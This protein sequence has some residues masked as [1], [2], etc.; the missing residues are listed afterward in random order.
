MLLTRI[1]YFR[2]VILMSFECPHCHFKNSEIQSAGQIQERGCKYTFTITSLADIQRQVIKSD[3]CVCSFPLLDLEIPAQR[4][5]L[6]TIEG[7]LSTVLEDLTGD[8][9]KRKD[10]DPETWQKIDEFINKGKDMLEGKSFP[11]DVVIDDISGNSWV[12]PSPSDP[13]GKWVRRD[14]LRTREQNEELSLEH[15]PEK[16]MGTVGGADGP[17]DEITK[18]EVYCFPASCPNC[19]ESCMTNMK[20]VEIPHFEEVVIMSTACDHCSCECPPPP[21]LL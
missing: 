6:T 12:E 10:V 20:M 5:K 7:L 15:P 3:T 21:F 19:Y 14:Y 17:T 9:E 18:D 4:G 2:E 8:Q 16:T 1:P 13:R 11:W